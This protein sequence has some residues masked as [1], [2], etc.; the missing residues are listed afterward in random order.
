M[1]NR[2]PGTRFNPCTFVMLAKAL[3]FPCLKAI[4][5]GRAYQPHC[6]FTNTS[7]PSCPGD[8]KLHCNNYSE[9]KIIE[10]FFFFFL[11]TQRTS[12]KNTTTDW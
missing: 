12:F 3:S 2:F 4:A 6:S 11:G 9:H 1:E 5:Q 7:G 10:V 8:M